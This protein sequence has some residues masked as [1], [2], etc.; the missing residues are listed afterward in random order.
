M[1]PYVN[2]DAVVDRVVRRHRPPRLQNGVAVDIE[3]MLADYYDI[4]IARI[5]D[6]RIGNASLQGCCFPDRLLILVEA[7]DAPT[8]QR[9][10][11]AHELGHLEM[12][13]RNTMIQPLFPVEDEAAYFRCVT[14][15]ATSEFESQSTSQRRRKERQADV[16]AAK[17]L[18]PLLLVRTAW[19]Q[20]DGNLERCAELLVVSKQAMEY[21]LAELELATTAL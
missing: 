1:Q 10:T 9:F 7:H 4:D 18:M 8:R 11:L 5:P 2:I 14:H 17:F 20:A 3:R 16:F 6:L 12:H 19:R 15:E 13:Y 21:R